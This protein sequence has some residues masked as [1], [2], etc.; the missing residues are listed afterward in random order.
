ML[1]STRWLGTLVTLSLIFEG[2]VVWCTHQCNSPIRER[3]LKRFHLWRGPQTLTKALQ[4]WGMVVFLTLVKQSEESMEV[5]ALGTIP[6]ATI[7][8]F[9]KIAFVFKFVLL[10]QSNP[11]LIQSSC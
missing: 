7:E 11:S 2:K 10:F 9:N 8:K 6:L 4:D 5:N 3:G 1:Q